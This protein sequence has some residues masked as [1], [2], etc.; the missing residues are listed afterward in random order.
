MYFNVSALP[1]VDVWLR[2]VSHNPRGTWDQQTCVA[3]AR[4]E[5][6]LHDALMRWC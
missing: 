2:L 3:A 5:Y 4:H 1:M 6:C